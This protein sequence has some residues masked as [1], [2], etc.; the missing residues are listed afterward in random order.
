LATRQLRWRLEKGRAGAAR[1]LER[2]V[3][4]EARMIAFLLAALVLDPC[5]IVHAR[6]RLPALLVRRG[7]PAGDVEMGFI[8]YVAPTSA[9]WVVIDPAVGSST[10]EHA[11]RAPPWVRAMLP[12]FSH[13]PHVGEVLRGARLR[14][15]LV[16]HLHWDHVSGAWDL[17]WLPLF[18]PQDDLAWTRR[19]PVGSAHRASVAWHPVQPLR[20][21]GPA[22]DGFPASLD[23]FGDD[24]V[25]AFPLR[26]H[27]PGSVGYLVNGRY[28]FIGDATWELSAAGKA[29]IA[30]IADEDPREAARS[31]ALALAAARAHP[32]WVVLPAHDLRAASVLPACD[33][34]RLAAV[35]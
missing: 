13:A 29:K 14:A 9:G 11:Q 26:G 25:V 21:D 17:P 16:T 18:A 19:L 24:S 30:A 7:L 4:A 28:F 35:P 1:P 22:R 27:T 2:G 20:L 12:D 8:T 15:I 34:K 6:A 5:A 31:L 3:Q 32:D 23:V 10:P 33:Q